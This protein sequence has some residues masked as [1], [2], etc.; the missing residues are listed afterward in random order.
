MDEL[1]HNIEKVDIDNN[2]EVFNLNFEDIDLNIDINELQDNVEN[3]E[4]AEDDG[5]VDELDEEILP[6]FIEESQDLIPL[7]VGDLSSY[8]ENKNKKVIKSLHRN[9]HTLKGT[10]RMAGAFKV[11]DIT[12]KMESV[13]EQVE[14]GLVSFD[15]I[16][17]DL[18]DKFDTI[19]VLISRIINPPVIQ[20]V[21]VETKDVEVSEKKVEVKNEQFIKVSV[22][23]IDHLAKESANVKISVSTLFDESTIIRKAI[24][25]LGDDTERIGKMLKELET[26]AET[27]M[28]SRKEQLQE[29]GTDFDPLEFDRFTRL[30]ELAR[31]ITEGLE[32]IKD[33]YVELNNIAKKQTKTLANQYRSVND[34]EETLLQARLIQFDTISNRFYKIVRLVAKEE[35]KKANLEVIGE[36]TDIDRGILDKIITPIEHLIRNS[37]THGLEKPSDRIKLG[38]KEVGTI[39]IIVRQEGDYV[40]IDIEDDGAGLN[41]EKIKQKAIEKGL[42]KADAKLSDKQLKELILL[43]GFS[44]ADAISQNAGRGVGMDVVKNQIV[45]LGGEL[46]IDTVQGKFARFSIMLPTSLATVQAILVEYGS[47]L[48]AVPLDLVHEIVSLKSNEMNVAIRNKNIRKNGKDYPLYYLP[49][50]M[51]DFNLI[52]ENKIYNT[53]LLVKSGNS[54]I[55]VLVD[56]LLNTDEIVFKNIGKQIAKLNG[57]SGA[58]VLGNGRIGVIINPVYLSHRIEMGIVNQVEDNVTKQPVIMIVDDSL[59]IRK[60]TSRFL[61]KQ[62]FAVLTAQNGE[63]ALEQLQGDLPDIMLVDVEMPKMDGFELTKNV[64]NNDRLKNIPIIMIT[65]RTAEK[66]KKHA[67]SLGANV[68]LGKP[69]NEEQLMKHVNEFIKEKNKISA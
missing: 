57:I 41:L 9:L 8:R 37:L 65:S 38:K 10:A 35:G 3:T 30:Q 29:E 14:K 59:T 49:N 58:T 15:D 50:L 31:F 44:T 63:D 12:H 2:E 61:T 42:I 23:T 53:I 34:I 36:T 25:E 24:R 19:Q 33:T 7:I 5:I 51:G 17:G 46:N 1:V 52:P 64:R 54:E 68:Y 26:H 62:G 43:P 56:K 6:L 45:E 22:D 67:F 18:E 4:S 13:M 40:Y 39:K 20:E 16:I 69:F 21:K 48:A 32:D 66:H 11:G 28:L 60:A 47:Q 27:Q 55:A